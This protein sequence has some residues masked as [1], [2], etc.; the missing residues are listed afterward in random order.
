MKLMMKDQP[1]FHPSSCHLPPAFSSVACFACGSSKLP[2]WGFPCL[3]CHSDR[4]NF[5]GDLMKAKLSRVLYVAHVLHIC[6]SFSGQKRDVLVRRKSKIC[7]K[8]EEVLL[9]LKLR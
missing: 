2:S 4:S 3:P 5:A 9:F 7:L 6:T 1:C 8:K